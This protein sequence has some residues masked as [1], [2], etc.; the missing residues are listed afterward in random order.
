MR[1][2]GVKKVYRAHS[3][4]RTPFFLSQ[5]V[6]RPRRIDWKTEGADQREERVVRYLAS[7]TERVG[8]TRLYTDKLGDLPNRG[9]VVHLTAERTEKERTLR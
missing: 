2:L 1:H 3:E 7:S 8:I 6:Q 9:P 5:C 4:R